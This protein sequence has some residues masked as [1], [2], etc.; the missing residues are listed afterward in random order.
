MPSTK[1]ILIE[2][3]KLISNEDNWC[4][5]RY[6]ED[7]HGCET[8]SVVGNPACYCPLGAVR[9]VLN[10]PWGEP[11]PAYVKAEITLNAAA[12]EVADFFGIADLNDNSSHDT[13][14]RALDIAIERAP[15]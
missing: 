7:E 3:R 12:H 14:L 8:D 6:A 9:H 5:E 2:A 11:C 1:S 4:Q 10:V 15:K 13:V